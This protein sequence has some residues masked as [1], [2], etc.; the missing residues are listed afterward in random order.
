MKVTINGQDYD[1]E[2]QAPLKEVLVPLGLV[3]PCH[4]NGK[5]GRCKINCKNIAPTSLDT[6]FLT[7][8]EID[9]G[10]RLACDKQLK[11]GLIITFQAT[12][13]KQGY[14]LKEADVSLEILNNE[15][16]IDLLDMEG[17]SVEKTTVFLPADLS[18]R[19]LRAQIVKPMLELFEKYSVATA[20]R[21]EVKAEEQILNILYGGDY[22]PYTEGVSIGFP[23]EEAVLYTI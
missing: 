22:E 15:A 11:D 20:N 8:S 18:T 19:T 5:C 9:L 12:E 7:Q 1:F 3:F 10:I 13:S 23:A 2:K 17:K 16:F 21:I 14:K 6:R 4:G